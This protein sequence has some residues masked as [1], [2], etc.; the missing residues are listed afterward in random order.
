MSG[1]SDYDKVRKARSAVKRLVGALMGLG[2]SEPKAIEAAEIAI[3]MA[4]KD[5]LPVRIYWEALDV[6][7]PIEK[8][9]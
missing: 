7:C 1:H 4:E 8:H 3:E 5:G 6:M 2:Y 9:L